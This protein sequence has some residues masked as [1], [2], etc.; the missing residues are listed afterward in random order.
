MKKGIYITIL[1]FIIAYPVF[2]QDTTIV[3]N[4]KNMVQTDTTNKKS[5][6]VPEYMTL[7][8]KPAAVLWRTFILPGWGQLY[9]EDYWKA[10]IFT[11]SWGV[12]IYMIYDNHTKFIEK[13]DIT[14]KMLTDDPDYNRLRNEREFYR[15]NRDLFSLYLLGVYGI[16]AIDAY[17]GAHLFD[18]DVNDDLT[19]KIQ[20]TPFGVSLIVNF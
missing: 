4:S 9:N 5:E 13:K 6:K 1:L 10:P 12:L 15:D 8:K 7:T 2:S 18:F 14:D 17:S 20:A 11:A 3:D 16:A 19:A